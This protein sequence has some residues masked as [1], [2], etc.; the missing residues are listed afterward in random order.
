MIFNNN[1]YISNCYY[2]MYVYNDFFLL[3]LYMHVCTS[4][5]LQMFNKESIIST[6]K[7]KKKL[8]NLTYCICKTYNGTKVTF[9][10]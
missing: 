10:A 6:K 8:L 5:N 3:Q 9:D 1:M 2:E 7:E 4:V